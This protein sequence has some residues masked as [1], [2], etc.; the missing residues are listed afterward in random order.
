[1]AAAVTA[2]GGNGLYTYLWSNGETT[3]SVNG[4]FA[5]TYTVTVTSGGGCTASAQ[6]TITQNATLLVSTAAT[7]VS[8]L[9]GNNGT[10]TATP[11]GGVAPYTYV[12]NTTPVQTGQIATGLTAGS[13]T[14][15]VTDAAGCIANGTAQV[16]SPNYNCNPA[17][18]PWRTETITSWKV[19]PNGIPSQAGQYMANNFA[20]AFPG[21]LVVGGGCVGSNTITLTSAFA[22]RS[23]LTGQSNAASGVLVANVINPSGA[24]LNNKLAAQC[25]ALKLNLVFDEYDAS[26]AS[27]NTVWYGNAIVKGLTGTM[28]MYNDSTVNK[29]FTDA[30]KKLGGC[31]GLTPT[32]AEFADAIELANL[33]Y[34]GKLQNTNAAFSVVCPFGNA[35]AG[36]DVQPVANLNLYPNPSN[37]IVNLSLMANR[38]GTM[39][40]TMYDITVRDVWTKTEGIMEGEVVRTYD[41]NT[42]AKGVYLL[43]VRVDGFNKT[44]R[45][46]IE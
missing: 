42:L 14:V 3:S 12:W 5:G 32:L 38:D 36:E 35:K 2:S 41:V 22:V 40:L 46:I 37:G 45:V 29:M 43:H 13:Y 23:F 7:P 4:L 28:A 18:K 15:V 33:E 9:N 6:V 16:L 8:V 44:I 39:L 26:F 34:V 24:S 11:S 31:A 17:T 27:L 20:A 19:V 21:S 1:M 10:A 25:V 30:Q